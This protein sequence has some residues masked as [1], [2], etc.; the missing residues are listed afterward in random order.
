MPIINADINKKI[1]E[2]IIAIKRKLTFLSSLRVIYDL[3]L[4]M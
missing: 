4:K 3:E 2:K 1:E